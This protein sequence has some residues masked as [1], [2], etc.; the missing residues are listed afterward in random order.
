MELF[1]ATMPDPQCYIILQGPNGVPIRSGKI[2]VSAV[3]HSGP[4]PFIS[5]VQ[6]CDT[7]S[8]AL[9][10]LCDYIRHSQPETEN[11]KYICQ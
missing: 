3:C 7:Y 5:S 11:N 10:G 1:L 8:S 9:P 4:V 2:R 6:C